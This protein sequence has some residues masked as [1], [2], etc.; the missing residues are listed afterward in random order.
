MFLSHLQV[1]NHRY[2]QTSVYHVK[3]YAC[4]GCMLLSLGPPPLVI[5]VHGLDGVTK[6]L[7][8]CERGMQ[9]PLLE[10]SRL[11]QYSA[12]RSPNWGSHRKPAESCVP[13]PTV[14]VSFSKHQP[15][16]N[17]W[18]LKETILPNKA[19]E[20]NSQKSRQR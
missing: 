2:R 12:S 7:R 9:L 11:S 16:K 19:R 6:G 8:F 10:A 4:T 3:N 20:M 15:S 13:C 17:R 18:V 1:S 5:S 14:Y